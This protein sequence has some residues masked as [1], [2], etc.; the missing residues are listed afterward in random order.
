MDKPNVTTV[1]QELSFTHNMNVYNTKN[2]EQNEAFLAISSMN[3]LLSIF[4]L[5]RVYRDKG[6][7]KY[8]SSLDKV[9][10][11]IIIL[12]IANIYTIYDKLQDPE[13]FR[14]DFDEIYQMCFL[15]GFFQYIIDTFFVYKYGRQPAINYL[16]TYDYI[17][18]IIGMAYYTHIKKDFRNMSVFFCIIMSVAF[19][20]EC[21]AY[22][23]NFGWTLSFV[24]IMD[25]V[26]LGLRMLGC[27]DIT[28]NFIQVLYRLRTIGDLLESF[29][30][31]DKQEDMI[32]TIDNKIWTT[33]AIK[34][35]R[36]SQ[37]KILSYNRQNIVLWLSRCYL[38]LNEQTEYTNVVY[39]FRVN[40]FELKLKFN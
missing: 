9:S 10:M 38:F 3:K 14:I 18:K 33:D 22:A 16:V 40:V 1:Q 20:A 31:M 39:G 11:I 25:Y 6:I 29:Y 13:S 21:L 7:L 26:Y 17:D 19:V 35:T 27:L 30:I 15:L 23:M 32:K 36:L 34:N 8:N 37:I 12:L 2:S 28:L 24:H 4:G 5:S